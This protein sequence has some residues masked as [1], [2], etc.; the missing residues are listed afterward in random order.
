MWLVSKWTL[1]HFHDYGRKGNH[2]DPKS[3]KDRV[4]GPLSKLPFFMAHKLG[5]GGGGGG[6]PNHLLSGMIL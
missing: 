6:D 3:H 2:G 5:G 1:F 4:V